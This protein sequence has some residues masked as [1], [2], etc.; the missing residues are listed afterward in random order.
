[1]WIYCKRVTKISLVYMHHHTVTNLFFLGWELFKIFFRN[2]KIYITV[3]LMLV[4]MLYITSQNLFILLLKVCTFWPSS[5]ISQPPSAPQ[6]ITSPFYLCIGGIFLFYNST[7]KWEHAVFSFSVWLVL[8]TLM[9]SESI[10]VGV[11]S[12]ISLFFMAD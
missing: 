10:H 4:T 3:W 8:L 11:N 12:K 1:M 5:P 6:A 9:P 2:F 7:C